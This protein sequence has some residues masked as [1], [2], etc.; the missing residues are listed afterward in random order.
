ML[1]RTEHAIFHKRKNEPQDVRCSL[2]VTRGGWRTFLNTR[3]VFVG[4]LVVSVALLGNLPIYS[5][6]PNLGSQLQ[7]LFFGCGTNTSTYPANTAFSI[8]QAWVKGGWSTSPLQDRASFNSPNT[9]FTLSVDG[10]GVN[11]IRYNFYNSTSNTMTKNFLANFP[12]GMSSVHTFTGEWNYDGS[13]NATCTV[14][15]TFN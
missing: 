10:I 11:V 2:R 13:L 6:P 14:Q 7:G 15:V 5:D 12:D 1:F 8:E 4:A 3:F 9:N